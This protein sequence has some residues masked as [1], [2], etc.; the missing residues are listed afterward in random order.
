MLCVCAGVLEAAG[1]N[2]KRVVMCH[3]GPYPRTIRFP[4]QKSS[5]KLLHRPLNRRD[6]FWLWQSE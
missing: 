1:A 4:S 2:L 6:K 5:Q 3:I